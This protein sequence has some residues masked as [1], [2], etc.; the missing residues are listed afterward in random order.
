[1][2][3]NA[4]LG[5]TAEN[6]VRARTAK[7]AEERFLAPGLNRTLG[8]D[9]QR[10]GWLRL[11]AD[12]S[13]AG[14]SIESGLAREMAHH[15]MMAAEGCSDHDAKLQYTAAQELL[16]AHRIG[17][18]LMTACN[19]KDRS[20]E[21]MAVAKMSGLAAAN[22]LAQCEGLRG[23]DLSTRGKLWLAML[24]RKHKDLGRATDEWVDEQGLYL[25]YDIGRFLRKQDQEE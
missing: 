25:G 21:V 12:Y 7:E 8:A 18:D 15:I 5:A 6:V 4:M 22:I 16:R 23:L 20:A 9:G 2:D 24:E 19:I 14:L 17:D 13:E 10:A 1:M 3:K 11:A